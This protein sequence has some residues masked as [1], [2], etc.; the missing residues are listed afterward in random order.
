MLPSPILLFLGSL[1]VALV[2]LVV[3][4]I[5]YEGGDIQPPELLGL[6]GGGYYDPKSLKAAKDRRAAEAAAAT[7]YIYD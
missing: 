7:R 1:F 2:L 5:L 3:L 4:C 6:Q